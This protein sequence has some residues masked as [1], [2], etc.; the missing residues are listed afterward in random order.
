MTDFFDDFKIDCFDFE[1]PELALVKSN[2][3]F[4]SYLHSTMDDLIKV[5][6][7]VYDIASFMIPQAN[8]SGFTDHYQP[9]FSQA[10]ATEQQEVE[11]KSHCFDSDFE[12]ELSDHSK[13]VQSTYASGNPT[14][15]SVE[16]T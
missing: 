11:S 3:V 8:S 9:T 16:K 7:S 6:Q 4:A 12:E 10:P 14:P 13:D 2:S 15:V 5:E 1:E